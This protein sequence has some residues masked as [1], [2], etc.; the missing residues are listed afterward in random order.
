MRLS[1][2]LPLFLSAL[3]SVTSDV[4]WGGTVGPDSAS[5]SSATPSV[6]ARMRAVAGRM[7]MPLSALATVFRLRFA[8][9]ANSSCD[10]PRFRRR[11]TIWAPLRRMPRVL[12]GGEARPFG[13]EEE[14]ARGIVRPP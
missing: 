8:L 14:V 1:P 3:L 10:H 12:R 9:P 13:D 6:S 11:A 4:V 2:A 5:P 7:A